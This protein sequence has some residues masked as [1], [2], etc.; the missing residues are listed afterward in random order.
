GTVQLVATLGG[1]SG[2]AIKGAVIT[3]SRDAQGVW[4]CNITKT[5]TAWKPNYAPANCPK[6]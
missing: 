4:S 1:S 5:P 6:S 3:V 2:S